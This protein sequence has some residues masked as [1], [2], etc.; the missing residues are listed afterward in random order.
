MSAVE[1]LK[2]DQIIFVLLF[3]V[4]GFV[5][6]KVYDLFVPGDMRNLSASVLEVVSYSM[7][8]WAVLVPLYLAI[9][10]LDGGVSTIWSAVYLFVGIALWP[11]LLGWLVF[12]ARAKWL[13]GK[14][15]HPAR[16]AW[17][18]LFSQGK[19]YWVLVTTSDGERFGGRYAE[20]SFATSYPD[21]HEIYLQ[22]LWRVDENGVFMEAVE[23]S[24]GILVRRD[25]VK[26]IEFFEYAK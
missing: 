25:E 13:R 22:E 16:T 26:R 12:N 6:L 9:G 2:Q 19:F 24:A 23:G 8:C 3:F 5:A 20:K 1:F 10:L 21:P 18:Y 17:D 11:A 14:I 15:L 7:L 4:P